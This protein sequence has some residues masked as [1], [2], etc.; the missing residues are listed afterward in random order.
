MCSVIE[1]AR[2]RVGAGAPDKPLSSFQCSA[3]DLLPQPGAE[4]T[5]ID[6]D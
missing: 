6:Q 4:E 3:P 1:S 2:K 5:G